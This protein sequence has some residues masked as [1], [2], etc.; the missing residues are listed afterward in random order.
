MTLRAVVA[1]DEALGRR[2]I[3]SRLAKADAVDVVAQCSNGREAIEAVRELKPDLLFLDV[4]M[5]GID[6]FE[7]VRGLPADGRPHVIF[8]TAWDKH[9][10]RAFQVEALDYLVKPIDDERFAEALERARQAIA[11]RRD[12]EIGRRVVAAVRESGSPSE[13]KRV[14]SG[15]LPGC[16]VVR[17]RGRV[18][19][20]RHADVDWI[21]GAG[22]YVR[23]HAADREWLLRDTLGAVEKRLDPRKFLR[24]HRSTIVRLDRI[25]ELRPF[26]N[27]D[28]SV[29]LI[30]GREL[31]ASRSY[32]GALARL[33]RPR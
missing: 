19:F 11:Q 9:A 14:P 30:D 13:E 33:I 6:G 26:E 4:Q 3:V 12:S 29:H 21:E 10:V 31:R 15:A 24:I 2:G 28:A 16:F 20:V 23:L 1:D 25:R 8:V 7:V 5:P 17:D 18:S 27:G 32:R 22:D